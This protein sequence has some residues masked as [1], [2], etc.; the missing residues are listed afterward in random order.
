MQTEWVTATIAKSALFLFNHHHQV[1]LLYHGVGLQ[2]N[3]LHFP[4]FGGYHG[5][6]HLHGFDHK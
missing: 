4:I 6:F 5:A 1:V 3:V 2:F